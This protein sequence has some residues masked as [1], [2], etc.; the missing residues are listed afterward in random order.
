[1]SLHTHLERTSCPADPSPV[2]ATNAT[3][4]A[5]A[6]PDHL[7]TLFAPQSE[8]PTTN[9][10][11]ALSTASTVFRERAPGSASKRIF[12]ITDND[13]P[14]RGSQSLINVAVNK[15]RDLWDSD[16]DLEC[17]LIPPRPDKVF[18]L[19]LFYDV[20]VTQKRRILA[21]ADPPLPSRRR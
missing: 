15:R 1:M 14:A 12:L 19:G 5:E 13:D 18:D 3:P 11:N 7:R 8:S 21:P 2:P 10:A 9:I 20:S 4:A 6:D 17:F 16:Y